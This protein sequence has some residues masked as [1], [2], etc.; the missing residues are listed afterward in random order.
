[1]GRDSGA[2]LTSDWGWGWEFSGMLFIIAFFFFNILD[3]SKLLSHIT[4]M[5]FVSTQLEE[6]GN[7]CLL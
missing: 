3:T 6:Y 2:V 4:S 1:M 7:V 5:V